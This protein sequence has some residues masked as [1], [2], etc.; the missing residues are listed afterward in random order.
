LVFYASLPH[1]G[2]LRWLTANEPEIATPVSRADCCA[3]GAWC[4]PCV[5]GPLGGWAC[6]L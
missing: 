4:A 5:R 6:S 1:G 2:W 3:G